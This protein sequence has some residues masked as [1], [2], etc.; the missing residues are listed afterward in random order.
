[1]FVT[2]LSTSSPSS[3][4]A[5]DK[6]TGVPHRYRRQVAGCIAVL[7]Y[8]CQMYDQGKVRRLNEEPEPLDWLSQPV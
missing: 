3:E 4:E 7:A 1:V 5:E 8:Y 6:V 2:Q